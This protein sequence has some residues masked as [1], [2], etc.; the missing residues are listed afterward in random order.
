MDSRFINTTRVFWKF[1]F[2]FFLGIIAFFILMNLGFFGD[3]PS[4]KE[5]ENPHSSLASEVLAEDGT[6]LGKF[7]LENRTNVEFKDLPK[8]LVNSLIATEDVRFFNHSGIDIKALLAV[9]SGQITGDNRGGGST[10]TQQL[11]KNLFPRENYSFVG[12]VFRKFKEWLIAIKLEKTFTKEEIIA[13]Y[14]NT[15]EFSDNAFGIKSASHTYF[16]KPLEDL[17]IQESALLVGMLK[18]T[19]KYNPRAHPKASMERRNVVINQLF[20]YDYIDKHLR[21]SLFKCPIVLDYNPD[22]HF[23]GLA[24]YFREYVKSYL[25]DLFSGSI[26]GCNSTTRPKSYPITT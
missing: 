23:E 24:P 2:R 4:L 12:L 15:V 6:L 18:A 11:A 26:S 8:N 9:I 16:N 25:K 7:Y 19:Y 1:T 20:E 10:I 14:F 22:V 21:D 5:L 17:N 3:M 13:G